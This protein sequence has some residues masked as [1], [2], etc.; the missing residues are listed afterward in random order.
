MLKERRKMRMIVNDA[1]G[2]DPDIVKM[3]MR[4]S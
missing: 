4:T 3:R 2:N 1:D